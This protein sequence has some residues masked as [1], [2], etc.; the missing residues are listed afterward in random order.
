MD[1]L[2]SLS[3]FVFGIYAGRE[4]VHVR[5]LKAIRHSFYKT[6]RFF[7]QNRIKKLLEADNRKITKVLTL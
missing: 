4:A 1:E 2:T 6:C 3:I 5:D 7:T